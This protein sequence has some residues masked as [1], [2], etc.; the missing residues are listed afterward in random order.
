M[1][2]LPKQITKVLLS[3][4]TVTPG[5]CRPEGGEARRIMATFLDS[6]GLK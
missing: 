5:E 2:C 6:I 1:A 4:M 3:M